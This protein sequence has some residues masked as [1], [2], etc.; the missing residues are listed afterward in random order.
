M[1]LLIPVDKKDYENANIARINEKNIWVT[2]KMENGYIEKYS[3][4]DNKDDIE[5]FVDYLIIK[6]KNDDIEEFLDD[7]IDVLIAP[8]QNDIEE[9]I[10]AYKFKELHEI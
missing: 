7:G 4:F 5:E 2:I 9:V 3:F 1:L 6:D 8:L 10:E